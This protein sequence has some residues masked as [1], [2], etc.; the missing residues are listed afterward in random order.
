MRD[1]ARSLVVYLKRAGGQS[2]FSVLVETSPAPQSALRIVTDAIT[3][4]P[5]ATTASGRWQPTRR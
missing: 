3:A 2:Q 4:N 5:G 1:V